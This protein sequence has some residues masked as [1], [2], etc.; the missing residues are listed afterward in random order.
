[1]MRAPALAARL[2]DFGEKRGGFSESECRQL[3][4]ASRLTLVD[5]H[6]AIKGPTILAK[7]LYYLARSVSD[8]LAMAMTPVLNWATVFD[9]WYPGSGNGLIVIARKLSE[10]A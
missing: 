8:R 7:E 2:P 9:P 6:R 3:L 10:H 4:E 5:L 1:M